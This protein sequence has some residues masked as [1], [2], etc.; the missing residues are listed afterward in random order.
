M[1]LKAEGSYTTIFCRG[2][3][4]VMVSKNLK[5][6]EVMLHGHG[7]LR[8]HNSHII[9]LDYIQKFVRTDGGYVVLTDN[10]KIEVSRSRKVEFFQHLGATA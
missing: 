1:H 7:F 3:K 6:F 8:V 5:A 4:P 2:E 9:N 10:S